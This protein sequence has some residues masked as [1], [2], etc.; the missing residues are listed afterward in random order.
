[1]R[2][3]F[4]KKDGLSAT[5]SLIGYQHLPQ[6]I[7]IDR[8]GHINPAIT[9]SEKSQDASAAGVTTWPTKL[10]DRARRP[11]A[12]WRTIHRLIMFM[13]FLGRGC[14]DGRTTRV[15]IAPFLFPPGIPAHFYPE[16]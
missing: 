7:Y 6:E 15:V 2:R 8:H 16:S 12:T 10:G 4:G 5:L 13:R 14:F 11:Y 9:A 1:V 3:G